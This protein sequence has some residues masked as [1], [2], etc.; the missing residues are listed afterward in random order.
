VSGASPLGI[1]FNNFR[2]SGA[3]QQ[4]LQRIANNKS[5]SPCIKKFLVSNT[6]FTSEPIYTASRKY[7][8]KK[9]NELQKAQLNEEDYQKEYQNVI[10]KICFCEGLVNSFYTKNDMLT[11]K[12]NKAVAICP[13]PNLAFFKGLYTLDQMVKHIYGKVNLLEGVKRPHVFINELKLY[14]DYLIKDIETNKDNMSTKKEKYLNNFYNQLQNGINYYKN[15]M[16]KVLMNNAISL[17]E[18]FED[19]KNLERKLEEIYL[20]QY[21]INR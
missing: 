15:L 1:P 11:V 19:L 12:E 9:I 17:K 4:R 6:E 14:I 16:P 2:K 5:G 10:E 18:F 20:A 13:G 7:Q 21:A 8:S 3:E